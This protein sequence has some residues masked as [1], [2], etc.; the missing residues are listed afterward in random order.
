MFDVRLKYDIWIMISENT[1]NNEERQS[2]Q[3]PDCTMLVLKYF[4]IVIYTNPYSRIE[5]TELCTVRYV[6]QKV[7]TVPR[8]WIFEQH[9]IYLERS[10]TYL[11]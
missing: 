10:S 6:S 8:G 4:R 11:I 5:R 7:Q 9:G 3:M 2:K 1:R